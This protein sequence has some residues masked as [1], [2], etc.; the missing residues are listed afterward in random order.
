LAQGQ[1]RRWIL[2]VGAAKLAS[3][4]NAPLVVISNTVPQLL[5]PPPYVVP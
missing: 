3:I 1:A 2:P 5:L 4:V